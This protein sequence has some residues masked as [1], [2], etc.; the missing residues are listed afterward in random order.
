MV[1]GAK[2]SEFWMSAITGIAIAVLGILV[3]YGLLTSEQS[4]MWMA[5]VVAVVPAAMAA[6]TW[7]YNN[8]RG[9]VKESMA[10]NAE[11]EAGRESMVA[12][13]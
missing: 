12:K 11:L 2:T 10:W 6:V 5:L 1:R 8:S 13:E 4:E 9:K 7:S 3:G